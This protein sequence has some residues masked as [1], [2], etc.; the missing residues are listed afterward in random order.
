MKIPKA[1]LE[2]TC[3]TVGANSS[4]ELKISSLRSYTINNSSNE[5]ITAYYIPY[6]LFTGHT[7]E[8]Y[9]NNIHLYN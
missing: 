5:D 8:Y 2:K 4:I 6:E 1:W 7:V 3:I 9:N